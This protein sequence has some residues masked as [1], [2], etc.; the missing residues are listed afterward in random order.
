[1]YIATT[2]EPVQGGRRL[3]CCGHDPSFGFVHTDSRLDKAAGYTDTLIE[4]AILPKSTPTP[5]P[6]HIINIVLTPARRSYTPPTCLYPMKQ[7]TT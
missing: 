1:M 7:T 4:W 6:M 2:V 3:H 5:T